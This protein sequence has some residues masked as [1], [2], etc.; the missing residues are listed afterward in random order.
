MC[1]IPPT[2]PTKQANPTQPQTPDRV[3]L[4]PLF[5]KRTIEEGPVEK[6][7]RKDAIPALTRQGNPTPSPDR[8]ALAPEKDHGRRTG[9]RTRQEG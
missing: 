5:Q 1:V 6:L 4:T 9:R 2:S 3:A 7:G 8:V